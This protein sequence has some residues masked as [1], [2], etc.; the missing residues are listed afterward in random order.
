MN[1]DEEGL[2][3]PPDA[4]SGYQGPVDARLADLR[5][6][7]A[8]EF[9]NNP[10]LAR[11]FLASTQAEVG[12]QSK[13]FQQGYVEAVLNRAALRHETL[14]DT[15][16]SDHDQ[17]YGTGKNRYQGYYDHKTIAQ[18]GKQFHPDQLSD[19]QG[20]IHNAMNGSNI[21]N[22]ATGNESDDLHGGPVALDAGGGPKGNRLIIESAEQ[23]WANGMTSSPPKAVAVQQ[24]PLGAPGTPLSSPDI[25]RPPT[26]QNP[27][28]ATPVL[29]TAQTDSD[30]DSD[31]TGPSLGGSLGAVN[32]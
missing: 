6:Q 26:S 18:L 9:Q 15:L 32:A 5:A 1:G 12:D 28:R 22:Y 25:V 21:S 14:D 7:F 31:Y 23:K 4:P 3:V 11:K 27:P 16:S 13:D 10:D 19:F 20:M 2:P 17:W 29:S 24:P 30:T 8:Q